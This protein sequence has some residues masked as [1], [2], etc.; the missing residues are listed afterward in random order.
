MKEAIIMRKP[1]L[2]A[3]GLDAEPIPAHTTLSIDRLRSAL[4]IGP[5]DV[6]WTIEEAFAPSHAAAELARSCH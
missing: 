6:R 1:Q 3:G 4:G 2:L 5:P